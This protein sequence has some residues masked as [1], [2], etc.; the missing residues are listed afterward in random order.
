MSISGENSRLQTRARILFQ[1]V[2]KDVFG[3]SSLYL[4]QLDGLER[5]TMMRSLLR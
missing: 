3:I 4:A 1:I 2:A 5:L